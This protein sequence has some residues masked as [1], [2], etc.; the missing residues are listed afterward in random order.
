MAVKR[1]MGPQN[2]ASRD[3]IFDAVERVLQKEGYIALTAR[4]VA[5]E[6]GFNHQTVYY[7]F[8]T[9]EERPPRL[10][11]AIGEQPEAAPGRL[12]LGP[13]APRDLGAL[14]RSLERPAQ[15]RVQRARDAQRAAQVGDLP[16][17]QHSR[18]LQD[19]AL[20]PLLKGLGLPDA[21]GPHGPGDAHPFRR[22]LPRPR[23]GARR[24]QG[25]RRDGGLVDWCLGRF[26]LVQSSAEAAA[27]LV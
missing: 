16:I 12:G 7:Y 18:A 11:A 24:H 5:E 25:A 1:R 26:E 9:M 13:A 20:A 8:E 6:A 17:S 14:Q 21:V 10:S 3:V 19:A 2:S 4:R 27:P 22:Q 15:R 23:S